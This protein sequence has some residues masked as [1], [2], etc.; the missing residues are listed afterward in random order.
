MSD[1]P[2]RRLRMLLSVVGVVL[3]VLCCLPTTT[4]ATPLPSQPIT[5]TSNNLNCQSGA[6][7]TMVGPRLASVNSQRGLLL[8]AIFSALLGNS[9]NLTVLDWNAIATAELD[10]IQLLGVLQS[11]LQLASPQQVLDT[12][13]TLLQVLNAAVDVAH[14]DGNTAAVNALNAIN[15]VIAPLTGTIR[16][17]DLIQSD[18]PDGALAVLE[19]DILS[20]LTGVISLFNYENVLTTPQPISVS[21]SA[22]GLPN[23]AETQLYAQVIE[24]PIVKC[25]P[26]GTEFYSAEIRIKLNI[27][28]LVAPIRVNLLGLGQVSVSLTQLGL[29]LDVARAQGSINFIDTLSPQVG[30]QVKP[31]IV[32]AYLGTI[33]DSIFFNRD[34][35]ITPAVVTYGTI[36]QV[37]V[38]GLTAS[39]KGKADALGN[40]TN[41]NLNFNGPFP[42]TKTVGTSATFISNLI[43]TLVNDLE[44]QVTPNILGL[45]LN[46]VLNIVRPL[47]NNLITPILSNVLGG[48]VDPLLGLLGIGIGEA[49]VTV[50]SVGSAQMYGACLPTPTPTAT[51]SPSNTP[52]ETPLPT[53]TPTNTPTPTVTASNTPTETPLP[54]NTSTAT[55]TPT[56]TPTETPLPSPTATAIPLQT[57][58][59]MV[60]LDSNVDGQQ[61]A[62]ETTRFANI[63]L[64]LFDATGTLVTTGT[65]NAEGQY[66][67]TAL[68]A[69]SYTLEIP[70]EVFGG[71]QPLNGYGLTVEDVG[72]D[73][74]D[75]DYY[76][77]IGGYY[78]A[79]TVTLVAGQDQNHVDA[80]VQSLSCEP[81]GLDIYYV[82]DTSSSM[83]QSYPGA[84]NK[85]EAAKEAISAA[86]DLVES[87]SPESRVG[88]LPFYGTNP[89]NGNTVGVTVDPLV[90]LTND[91]DTFDGY[92]AML[93]PIGFTPTAQAIRASAFWLWAETNGTNKPI[94]ILL[95]DG[96]PSVSY[97]PDTFPDPMSM[98]FAYEQDEVDDVNIR[99]GR[100]RF[101]S[102]GDVRSMGRILPYGTYTKEGQVYTYTTAKP[103]A[104]TMESVKYALNE[105]GLDNLT[106]H[107][108]AIQGNGPIST[109]NDGIIEYVADAGN[110]VF[111]NPNS[112]STLLDALETT[113]LDSSCA[114]MP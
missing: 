5:T 6:C 29:Y 16:L 19:M 92:M 58:H 89:S 39:L 30:V 51:P 70:A 74:T 69:G 108:I 8:N 14:A 88:L 106:M 86:N 54:T 98:G 21:G 111:V 66:T 93:D 41:A 4:H 3:I 27:N 72:A 15:V 44:L 43:S 95:S 20:L 56:S 64:N 13:L 34:A 80:G 33:S 57:I 105:M 10:V 11:D 18:F 82:L 83:E 104:D 40:T 90:F 63:A 48:L 36:G 79:A 73:E 107:G 60:W 97:D 28:T 24:P 1:A 45:L 96:V 61:Q 65:T 38:G 37:T 52:T 68:P 112:L 25:G 47:V 85:L 22:L 55:N 42:Q 53:N 7:L 94:L 17:G 67:F 84:V 113:I 100:G 46:T 59:G 31:G 49:D 75:S 32:N 91:Y 62:T 102:I 109:F 87:L 114:E 99:D 76:D 101:V 78:A 9:V 26:A 77:S 2:P 81:V 12:D 103:V 71:N 23:V 110:G 50:L 35:V